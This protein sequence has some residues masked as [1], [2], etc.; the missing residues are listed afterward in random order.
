MENDMILKSNILSEELKLIESERLILLEENKAIKIK[1]NELENLLST[2]LWTYCLQFPDFSSI[3]PIISSTNDIPE[4]DRRISQFFFEDT[5]E[6]MDGIGI[7]FYY[8]S[9]KKSLLI[10]SS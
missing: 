10:F 8:I 7:N 5:I 2:V 3:P 1:Q 4:T 9:R 6:E